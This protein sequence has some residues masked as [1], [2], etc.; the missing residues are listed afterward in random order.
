M[1]NF[2]SSFN[3]K[4][5]PDGFMFPSGC[6]AHSDQDGFTEFHNSFPKCQFCTSTQ[7]DTSFFSK[8]IYSSSTFN[9]AFG[10]SDRFFSNFSGYHVNKHCSSEHIRHSTHEYNKNCCSNCQCH[11]SHNHCNQKHS[12]CFIDRERPTPSTKHAQ[13]HFQQDSG[14]ES[15]KKETTEVSFSTKQNNIQRTPSQSTLETKVEVNLKEKSHVHLEKEHC[16]TSTDL[17]ESF[18]LQLHP[19]HKNQQPIQ[20]GKCKICNFFCYGVCS[21]PYNPNARF[22]NVNFRLY[23]DYD[24]IPDNQIVPKDTSFFPKTE[25]SVNRK[26]FRIKI[27]DPNR[28]Y[29]KYTVDFF[30]DLLVIACKSSDNVSIAV[31]SVTIAGPATPPTQSKLSRKP[32][33]DILKKPSNLFKYK[34]KSTDVNLASMPTSDISGTTNIYVN[35]DTHIHDTYLRKSFLLSPNQFDLSR[36]NASLDLGKR[37]EVIVPKRRI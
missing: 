15:S 25:L 18:T 4:P 1:F 7:C 20:A 9:T 19:N 6:H 28:I 23:P 27:K 10:D 11:H 21:I 2:E 33:Q 24:F 26:W 37:F 32:I 34:S 31:P 12:T 22:K 5:A 16:R 30:G 35:V 29:S 36:A 3:N 13:V 17:K 14:I 8:P